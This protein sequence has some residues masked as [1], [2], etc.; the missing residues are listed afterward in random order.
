ME[1]WGGKMLRLSSH[2]TNVQVLEKS[3]FQSIQ[4]ASVTH[5]QG[6]GARVPDPSPL[7]G[8]LKGTIFSQKAK[9]LFDTHGTGGATL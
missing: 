8:G 9:L 5:T 2:P 1:D 6:I 3:L 4:W 7:S